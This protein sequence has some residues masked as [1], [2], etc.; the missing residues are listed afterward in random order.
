MGNPEGG[1]GEK[2]D[3]AY[4][5]QKIEDLINEAELSGEKDMAAVLAILIGS[6]KA[7]STHELSKS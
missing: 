4:F 7:K 5:A 2:K 3:R 1:H 6:I